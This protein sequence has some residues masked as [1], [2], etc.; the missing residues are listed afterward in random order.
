MSARNSPNLRR[1]EPNLCSCW[2]H[3]SVK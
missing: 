3:W 2:K 1:W